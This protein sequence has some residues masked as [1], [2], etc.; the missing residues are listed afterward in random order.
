MAVPLALLWERNG[1]VAALSLA[2]L[3]LIHLTHRAMH[4]LELA[5]VTIGEQNVQLEATA[6]VVVQRST[7]AL[8]AL[9]ATVDARDA[10]TAGHSRRVRDVAVVIGAELGLM[11][12]ELEGLAQSA[13]L[14]DIG[15]IG[16]PD[17]VLLKEG[18]LGPAEWL[19]MKSHPEEGARI[20]ERLGYLDEVVPAI[21]HHH[22]RLDGRGYPAGLRGDEV[23]LAARIIH[24]A[25]ALDA[26]VTKRV[27]RDAMSFGD[28]LEEIRDGSGNDFCPRCVE[29]VERTVTAGTLERAL[30]GIGVAKAGL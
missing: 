22:E 7:A 3:V 29:A 6:E 13:L 9:S 28:A 8:E 15:K 19:V 26:M 20:I 5:S 24:V 25:D 27:Y 30:L 14:H 21:R 17:A 16:I 1:W 23:P 11:N 4:Q 2:P 12:H 10:Y 18:P